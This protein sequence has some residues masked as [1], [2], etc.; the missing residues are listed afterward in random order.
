M[1]SKP[2]V[3]FFSEESFKLK[4]NAFLCS[5]DFQNFFQDIRLTK[6]SKE[7][8]SNTSL[9]DYDIVVSSSSIAQ[10]IVVVGSIYIVVASISIIFQQ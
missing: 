5:G 1:K 7:I 2:I 8:C 9:T 10:F 4:L 6:E 3:I